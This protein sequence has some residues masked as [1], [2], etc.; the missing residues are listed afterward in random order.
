M[1]NET[2]S[3]DADEARAV[4]ALVASSRSQVAEWVRSG[5]RWYDLVYGATNGVLVLGIGLPRPWLI[6]VIVV[7]LATYGLL[8]AR[9]R[10]ATGIV[11]GAS[12]PRPRAL[13]WALAAVLLVAMAAS[14]V[15]GSAGWHWLVVLLGI[16]A[17][18]ASWFVSVR[19]T[20]SL[21]AMLEATP[22]ADGRA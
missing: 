7:A 12:A 18:V 13:T 3:P 16:A 2:S 20:A 5:P 1:E 19:Y 17:A 6:I 22:T 21:L 14:F 15:A 8:M 9:F 11:L 10:R 4:L